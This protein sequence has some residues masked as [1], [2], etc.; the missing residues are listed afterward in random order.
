MPGPEILAVL[1]LAAVAWYWLDSVRARDTAVEAARVACEGEGLLL[2]DDTVAIARIRPARDE[3]GRVRLQR[4]Y[5]FEYSDSGDNRLKGSIVL[6]GRRVVML[7]IGVRDGG[8][9]RLR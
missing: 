2:L 7:N 1:A 3:D 8:Y 4:A 5:E 6:L 9:A